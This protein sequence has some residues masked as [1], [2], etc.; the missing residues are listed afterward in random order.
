MTQDV[1]D[2]L[3]MSPTEIPQSV[4]LH[5]FKQSVEFF[6]GKIANGFLS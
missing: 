6:A 2:F 3:S 4:V 1:S 5:F